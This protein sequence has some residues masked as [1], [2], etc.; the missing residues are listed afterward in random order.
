MFAHAASTDQEPKMCWTEWWIGGGGGS[1]G[2]GIITPKTE[3]HT[4]TQ[5]SAA[6]RLS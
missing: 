5:S 2:G 1:G 4:H 6:N 3:H